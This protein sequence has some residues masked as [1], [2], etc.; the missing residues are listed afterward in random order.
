M[1]ELWPDPQYAQEIVFEGATM[2]VL[3]PEDYAALFNA[4]DALAARLAQSDRRICELRWALMELR[5]RAHAEGRRPEI[6]ADMSL[7]DGTIAADVRNAAREA[8]APP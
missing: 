1:A 7:I 5:L 6:D 2:I 4:H 3:A 8:P